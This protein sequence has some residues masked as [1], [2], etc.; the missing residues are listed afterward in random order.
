V[1]HVC[2]KL[3][4]PLP[5]PPLHAGEGAGRASLKFYT[6]QDASSIKTAAL[7][8]GGF[9]FLNINAQ[10]FARDDAWEVGMPAPGTVRCC[11]R[12]LTAHPRA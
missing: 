11:Y 10:R 4:Q 8:R 1:D 5:S 7:V 12:L 3:E 2:G 6:N 9:Y